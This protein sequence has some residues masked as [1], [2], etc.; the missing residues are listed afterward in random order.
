MVAALSTTAA[1]REWSE[2]EAAD[3]TYQQL[4]ARVRQTGATFDTELRAFR[5]TMLAIVGRNDKDYQKLRASRASATDTDDDPAAP[6]PP[7]PVE[8]APEGAPG[9]TTP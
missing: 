9:P 5:R 3:S 7:I 4:L 2:A 8:P 6:S 1:T